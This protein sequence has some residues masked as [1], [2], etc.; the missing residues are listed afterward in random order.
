MYF[1]VNNKLLKNFSEKKWDIENY[2]INNIK[3]FPLKKNSFNIKK[4]TISVFFFRPG[5]GPPEYK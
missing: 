2:G 4:K 3:S 1:Y 5:L